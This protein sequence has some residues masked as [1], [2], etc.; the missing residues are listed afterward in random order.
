MTEP[1]LP[2]ELD[3]TVR[4]SISEILQELESAHLTLSTHAL[5]IDNQAPRRL[6]TDTREI[7]SGDIFLAYRG[8]VSDHHERI[9]QAIDSGAVFI[10]CE[11]IPLTLP[12]QC[13]TYWSAM[14]VQRGHTLR[15]RICTSAKGFNANRNYRNNGKTAPSGISASYSC[16]NMFLCLASE[17]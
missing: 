17:L 16:N 10:I 9:P 13:R 5:Q 6:Q 1:Q 11:Y 14:P 15:P 8:V 12:L 4:K 2:H 3:S 7:K